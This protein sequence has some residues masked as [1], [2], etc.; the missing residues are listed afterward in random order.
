MFFFCI[1][2]LTRL[3][4]FFVFQLIKIIFSKKNFFIAQY[5]IFLLSNWDSSKMD[6]EKTIDFYVMIFKWKILRLP[7]LLKKNEKNE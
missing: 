2:R 6:I 3:F 1:L 4:F 7:V 5:E